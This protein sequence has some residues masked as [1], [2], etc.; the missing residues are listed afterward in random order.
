MNRSIKI[1]GL[2]M[3]ML[4]ILLPGGCGKYPSMETPQK[5]EVVIPDKKEP[6]QVDKVEVAGTAGTPSPEYTIGAEDVLEIKVWDHEDLNRKVAV[7]RSGSFS[8][9]LVGKVQAKGLT[10]A[11]LQQSLETKLGTGYIVNPQVSVAVIEYNSQ[12]VHVIGRV[13]KSATFKLVGPT[14]VLE[15]LS[16]ADGVTEDAGDEILVIRPRDKGKKAGP[17]TPDQASAS[18]VIKLNLQ[19]VRRGDMSQNIE[20]IHGDTVYVPVANYVYIV[21]E[22]KEPGKIKLEEGMTVLQ[23]ISL[24]GGVNEK[25]TA[26]RLKVIREKDG[27]RD[28][29]PIDMNDT[30]HPDDVLVVPQSYF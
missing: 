10:A 16:Q 3:L 26:S 6:V 28:E 20:L 21:G 12:K 27:V 30:L 1:A 4:A 14:S 13:K 8:F 24:A 18:E 17:L 22:V 9:P 7:P 23:A 5:I 2:V 29:I 25:G 15:I 19:A 11:Q